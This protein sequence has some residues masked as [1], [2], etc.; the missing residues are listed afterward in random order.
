MEGSPYFPENSPEDEE[1]DDQGLEKKDK[2]AKK[3]S[4]FELLQKEEDKG[5]KKEKEEKVVPLEFLAEDEK[6]LAA[7]EFVNERQE[8][9]ASTEPDAEDVADLALLAK[10]EEKLQND[11]PVTEEMLDKAVAETLEDLGLEEEPVEDNSEE[12]DEPE[13]DDSTT[14]PTATGSGSG[15][16]GITPPPSAGGSGS[17]M[18]PP[19]TPPLSPSPPPS[20]SGPTATPG[21]PPIIPGPNFNTVP[22][23]A[24]TAPNQPSDQDQERH[25]HVPYVL[26][27]GIVGYL[28]GRRRG[29]IKTEKR[30]LP[31]Q[32]K[33]QKE[34]TNLHAQIAERETKIRKLTREQQ[35]PKTVLIEKL[36]QS[37]QQKQ[38]QAKRPEMLGKFIINPEVAQRQSERLKPV[39]HM[40]LSEL[41]VVANGI[42][43][44][45]STVKKLYEL[46]RLNENSLR[47]IIKAYLA[48][49]RIERILHESLSHQLSPEQLSPEQLGQA[50][51]YPAHDTDNPVHGIAAQTRQDPADTIRERLREANAGASAPFAQWVEPQ[52]TAKTGPSNQTKMIASV[53]TGTVIAAIVVLFMLG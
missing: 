17:G 45:Q 16:L 19:P 36:E 30:L 24:N 26:A 1:D 47:K 15:G 39:E 21:M 3:P 41:L 40:S 10:I 38:E 13:E 27:G 52:K 23:A 35:P 18:P 33:L 48:G 32:E 42:K 7:E 9:I 22:V 49:E 12:A 6:K 5:E 4:L 20:A 31:I 29:R 44:E 50:E 46:G 8:D 11:E 43:A 14:P 37:R 2:K 28:I 51:F 53:A 34:V 25:S